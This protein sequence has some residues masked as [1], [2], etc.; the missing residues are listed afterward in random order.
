[1]P[2]REKLTETGVVTM[3]FS[4]IHLW[5]TVLPSV[6]PV[7]KHALAVAHPDGESNCTV[8]SYLSSNVMCDALLSIGIKW[9][10]FVGYG[11]SVLLEDGVGDLDRMSGHVV[12]R[13]PFLP[14]V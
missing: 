5:D 14:H 3:P 7:S 12:D 6:F 10:R 2:G 1:M 4:C 8:V 9:T 13:W 11:E